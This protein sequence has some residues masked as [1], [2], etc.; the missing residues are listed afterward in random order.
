M[1]CRRENYRLQKAHTAENYP[2]HALTVAIARE[3]TSGAASRVLPNDA[4]K[5]YFVLTIV[6]D[7]RN[8]VVWGCLTLEPGSSVV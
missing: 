5:P 1:R 3:A 7:L 2:Q 8:A 6:N 4:T